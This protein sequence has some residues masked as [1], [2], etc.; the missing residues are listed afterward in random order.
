MATPTFNTIINDLLS[1]SLHE[2]G[3]EDLIALF[4]ANRHDGYKIYKQNLQKKILREMDRFYGDMTLKEKIDWF[5]LFIVTKLL[6]VNVGTID[7]L[8]YF[9]FVITKIN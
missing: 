9:F 8:C 7:C 5:F 2:L 6:N 1:E 4:Y 3:K